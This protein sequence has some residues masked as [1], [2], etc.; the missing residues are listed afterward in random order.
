MD[1]AFCWSSIEK[2]LRLQPAHQCCLD[3]FVEHLAE[4]ATFDGNIL[5]LYMTKKTELS[6]ASSTSVV[7]LK[8]FISDFPPNWIAFPTNFEL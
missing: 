4:I 7:V 6:K 2:D 5:N 8:F 1:L 3:T